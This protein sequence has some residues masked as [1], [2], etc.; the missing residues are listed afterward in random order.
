[1][2]SAFVLLNNTNVF[3]ITLNN[4]FKELFMIQF[5]HSYLLNGV[6]WTLG[7]EMQYYLI[8]PM[9]AFIIVRILKKSS[10]L[11][12]TVYF[13]LVLIVPFSYYFLNW[14][15]DSRNLFGN[16][17]HFFI[18]MVACELLNNLKIKILFKYGLIALFILIFVTNILYHINPFI[19]YNFIGHFFVD[20][21]ILNLIF[22]HAEFKHQNS[23]KFRILDKY[24]V[25]SFF[26]K[27]GVISYGIYAWHPLLLKYLPE[28]F[29]SIWFVFLT[30]WGTSYL[31]F[32]FFEEK[33]IK[34][35]KKYE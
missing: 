9:I 5:N 3:P 18:G 30:T 25:I 26:A 13:I 21:I 2:I 24:N 35:N 7:I 6:F 22:L 1:M 8:A 31:S 16:L 14:S 10:L 33:I 32:Q 29:K 15:Y 19:Y 27:T 28:N 4:M 12:I 34:W 11:I 17:S 20:L 23:L